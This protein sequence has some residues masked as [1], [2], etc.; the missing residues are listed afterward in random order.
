MS[1]NYYAEIMAGGRGTRLWPLSRSKRPKQMLQLVGDRS[2]FQVAVDRITPLF[3]LDKILVVTTAEQAVAL[4]KQYPEIPKRNFITEPAPRGTASAIGLT[5][6]VLNKRDPSAIMA[7]LTAEHFIENEDRFIQ[8]L[9]AAEITAMDDSLVTWG[10]QPT[11]PA[12]GFGY[13]Q[14]GSYLTAY[15]EIDVFLAE[16]FLEKP[17][18]KTAGRLLEGEDHSWNSGMFIWRVEKIMAE[19]QH[20]MPDLYAALEEIGSGLDSPKYDEIINRVWLS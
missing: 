13:I 3:S 19:F 10:I 15:K 11:F 17:D 12:T 1:V 16:S 20:Q 14:Q 7:V 2:L 4:Q 5:A 18:L 6:A 9:K 8:V